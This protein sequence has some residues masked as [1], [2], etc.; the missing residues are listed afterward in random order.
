MA[1]HY[2]TPELAADPTKLPNIE[3]F[4]AAFAYC[5]ECHSLSY[6]IAAPTAGYSK[7]C[8]DRECQ[9][10]E[11][12]VKLDRFGWFY[13]ICQPGCLPDSEPFGP[14]ESEEAALKDARKD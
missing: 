4:Q 11:V 7:P 12:R 3:T 14:F 1:F 9:M 13:W 8:E 10:D 6:E 5:N 2:F